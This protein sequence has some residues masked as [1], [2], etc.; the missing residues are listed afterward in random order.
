MRS[1]NYLLEEK[2]LKECGLVG[3]SESTDD[4]YYIKYSKWD[5]VPV[6]YNYVDLVVRLLEFKSPILV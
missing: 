4:W 2:K 1:L 5:D 6:P 3:K